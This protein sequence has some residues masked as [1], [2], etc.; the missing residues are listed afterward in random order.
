M[1]NVVLAVVGGLFI[2]FGTL[3]VILGASSEDAK[4]GHGWAF[5]ILGIGLVVVFGVLGGR[6]V[7]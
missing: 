6:F 7:S 4:P 1:W 3:L 2:L 5:I